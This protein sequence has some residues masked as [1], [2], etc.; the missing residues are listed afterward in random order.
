MSKKQILLIY[1]NP[2][3]Y[4]PAPPYGLEILSSFLTANGFEPTIIS[5]FQESLRPYKFLRQYLEK[6][7]PLVIGVSF[8]N[9]D[10]AGFYYLSEDPPNFISHLEKVIEVIRIIWPHT[11]I[12]MGGSAFSISPDTLLKRLRL[13]FGISGP[14]EHSLISFINLVENGKNIT[15]LSNLVKN[16]IQQNQ[17]ALSG[18]VLR[19]DDDSI[20]FARQQGVYLETPKRFIDEASYFSSKLLGG[21]IPIRT[22]IGC[23]K[24][25]SY[26]VVPHIEPLKLRGYD[27]IITEINTFVEREDADR[28][29]LAD[30]EIN[31]PNSDWFSGLLNSLIVAFGDRIRWRSYLYPVV[32]FPQSIVKLMKESGCSG[33]SFTVDSFDDK[34][35]ALMLKTYRKVHV[36]SMLESLI[37]V[38][39]ALQVTL[40]IGGPGETFNSIDEQCK[41]IEYYANKGVKFFIN[42]GLRIYDNTPLKTIALKRRFSQYSYSTPQSNIFCS[43]VNH[44]DLGSLLNKRLKRVNNVRFW[45]ERNLGLE[46]FMFKVNLGARA[47]VR[48]QFNI[49]EK[50]FKSALK[51]GEQSYRPLLGIA[52]CYA[53]MGKWKQL[54]EILSLL[55]SSIDDYDEVQ[56][57]F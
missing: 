44:K 26:C 12:I 2:I 9:W 49:A 31:L 27:A 52:R 30:S 47:I 4:P 10:E 19:E 14:G 8:R 1:V 46:E 6:N 23:S 41:I 43:P 32:N 28:F 5:P 51:F 57:S 13:N 15:H 55:E 50:S 35:L 24:K 11:P 45:P 40:L 25:C 17:N 48:S 3:V 29:F 21:T 42:A 20:L 39:K 33:I 36:L 18:F 37:E 54:E 7:E 16:E 34:V 56:E 53:K 22:K 38:G